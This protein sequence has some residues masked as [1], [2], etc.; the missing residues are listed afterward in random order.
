MHRYY[1]A[2]DGVRSLAVG[3]VL[4]AH[5]GVS[6]FRSGGVGVDL[7]FVLSGF[8]ITSIL[9][10]EAG[11]TGSLNFRNFY[12]RRFLRLAPCLFLTC[13]FVAAWFWATGGR[14]PG[15]A[16]A[17]ALTYTANWARA[18]YDADLS[19]L[20][21][22]WS[23]AIEEQFYLIWPLV[24]LG[25]ERRVA[26]A[27]TKGLLLLIGA[28]L[29]AVYRAG[30]VGIYSDERINYGLDT[31][32]D[33]LMTGAALAYFARAL[34]PAGLSD[35]A[36][37]LLGRV[38]APGALGVL[39]LIPQVVT[40]YSPWMGRFGYVIVATASALLLADLVA[41]RH[42]L[43]ARPFAWGPLVYV[44]RI[45]YGIYL[46]HLPLYFI[47][48]AALPGWSYAE[49]LPLKLALTLAFAAASFR[50]FERPFLKLKSRFE[51]D[52]R[53]TQPAPRRAA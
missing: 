43:L 4:A 27:R 42:S 7:F 48:E 18:F 49:K 39:L 52:D 37:R 35:A 33:S 13:A 6:W 47:V 46:L 40:W 23:L 1:P 36:S 25:L 8:L 17:Y 28:L 15:A 41:G 2:L 51:S 50:F 45:S 14:V 22:C 12:V 30:L 44:G 32:M 38:L 3:I 29:V 20:T 34:P 24:I 21:H 26:D 31:R 53:S 16:I 5:G 19:W 9:A 10:A 11:A